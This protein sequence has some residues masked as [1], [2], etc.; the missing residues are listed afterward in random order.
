MTDQ[1]T[2]FHA[3]ARG[4]CHEGWRGG[5]FPDDLPE[6]WRLAYYANECRAVVVPAAQ[7]ETVDS[8]EV[9]R[10]LEDTPERFAFYLEVVDLATDWDRV[11]RLLA[12]L[13]PRIKGV[14]L[15]PPA[16]DA[17]LHLLLP[18]LEGIAGRWPVS[19]ALPEGVEPSIEG[20][21][22]LAEWHVATAWTIGRGE[23]DWTR[24]GL[25]VARVAGKLTYTPREWRDIIE[26]CL[27]AASGRTLL[28]MLEGE[29]PDVDALRAAVL[30]GDLLAHQP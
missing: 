17:D 8:L 29:P 22:V 7:W 23:P 28:V 13:F 9:E 12:P 2:Q 11:E 10:W 6:D 26:R 3:A 14:V 1:H 25:A 15:R 4:W 20:C 16:V 21:Q 19:L 30:I 27:K 24:D 18:A 5:F